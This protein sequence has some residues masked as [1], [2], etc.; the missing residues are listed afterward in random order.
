MENDITDRADASGQM[1]V[2]LLQSLMFV[3]FF[4]LLLLLN[5]VMCI[6]IQSGAKDK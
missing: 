6:Q 4:F 1:N 3:S 2:K 5:T